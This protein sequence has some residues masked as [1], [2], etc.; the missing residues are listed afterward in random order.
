MTK[1]DR[2]WMN[3]IMWRW[4]FR[5]IM[6]AHLWRKI[7]F[8]HNG[9]SVTLIP[10]RNHF[11]HKFVTE[12]LLWRFGWL[13]WRMHIV[14]DEHIP[15]SACRRHCLRAP[16]RYRSSGPCAAGQYF[17]AAPLDP[18]AYRCRP[19]LFP[20]RRSTGAQL[21]AT[22]LTVRRRPADYR[23]SPTHLRL[24]IDGW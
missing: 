14:I 6:V 12:Y 15:S 10:W 4:Q 20:D 3:C 18:T 9:Q 22:V 8:R 2:H 21:A 11:R 13:L 5:H 7:T 23:R 16:S 19:C 1:T 24:Q 17:L